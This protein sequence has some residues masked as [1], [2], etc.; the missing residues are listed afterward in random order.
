MKITLKILD[1]EL[2]MNYSQNEI[3]YVRDM[4]YIFTNLNCYQPSIKPQRRR[5]NLADNWLITFT[6]ILYKTSDLVG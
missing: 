6:E 4:L 3:S 1:E 2:N 5:E